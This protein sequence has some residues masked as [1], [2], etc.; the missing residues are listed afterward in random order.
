MDRCIAIAQNIN[1]LH[2]QMFAVLTVNKF[3]QRL[4]LKQ[5]G[6]TGYFL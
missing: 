2:F 4:Q 5:G 6:V 1:Y 3:R